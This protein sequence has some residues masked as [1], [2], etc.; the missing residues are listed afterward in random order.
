M[1][2]LDH[3]LLT[4]KEIVYTAWAKSYFTFACFSGTY[5]AMQL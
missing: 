4:I 2:M 5:V 3:S 1:R